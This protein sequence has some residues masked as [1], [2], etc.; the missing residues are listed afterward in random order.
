VK[1]LL[2]VLRREGLEGEVIEDK[3]EPIENDP[4]EAENGLGLTSSKLEV[5]VAA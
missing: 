2:Q 1:Q 4:G 3:T 5:Y